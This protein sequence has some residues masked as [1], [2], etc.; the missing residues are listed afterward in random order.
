MVPEL[1]RK[2]A[3]KRLTQ[4]VAL[5]LVA[6]LALHGAAFAQTFPDRGRRAVVDAAGVIPDT[7]E[8]ALD[9]RI[10]AWNR[11]T[12]RQLAVATVSGLEGRPIADYGN[13]LL[14]HWRL[15]GAEADDGL[16]LLLAPNEREVRI[17]VGYGLEP[18][19][20]DALTG[21]I[22]RRVIRPRLVEGDVAG[23]LD[24]GA[25]AIMDIV[26]SGGPAA[27]PAPDPPRPFP[28][29]WTIAGVL[30]LGF[31]ILF[32]WPLFELWFDLWPLYLLLPGTASRA[33][34]RYDAR[35][36]AYEE[37]RES[38][39]KELAE[40]IKLTP[41]QR[42]SLERR[43][44]KGFERQPQWCPFEKRMLTA[45]QMAER[46]RIGQEREQRLASPFGLFGGGSDLGRDYSDSG[47]SWD[48]G[49]DSGS[50]SDS[51]FDGGGSSG[52]GGAEDSY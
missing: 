7:A 37:K 13:R 12:G 16:L 25:S 14:R 29:F 44:G 5:L 1:N 21:Q 23:A 20:T 9:A 43:Y 32:L 6:L 36:K 41:A 10:L 11:A 19:L 31:L 26:G 45:A 46:A 38:D 51:G 28:W 50:S 47:S 22:I 42:R 34:A 27:E 15:G 17:E 2:G 30:G 39:A 8:A 33:R 40:R 4:I 35:Q 52:G 48:S 3:M 18:V 24:S 49:Y